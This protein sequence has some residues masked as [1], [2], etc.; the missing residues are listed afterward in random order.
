M[1]S[2]TVLVYCV[3]IAVAKKSW[4][5]ARGCATLFRKTNL[6][7]ARKNCEITEGNKMV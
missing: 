4:T 3:V 7:L 2:R 5:R 1:R 6:R